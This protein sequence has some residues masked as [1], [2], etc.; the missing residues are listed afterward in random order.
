MIWRGNIS[1]HYENRDVESSP[2]ERADFG[3]RKAVFLE[4]AFLESALLRETKQGNDL[5]KTFSSKVDHV[6]DSK[7]SPFQ[8]TEAWKNRRVIPHSKSLWGQAKSTLR[9]QGRPKSSNQLPRWL[10]L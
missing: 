5:R 7:T 2:Y 9:L 10:L 8:I 4:S 1:I 3:D 6:G